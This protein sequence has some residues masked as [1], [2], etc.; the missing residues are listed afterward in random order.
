MSK[1]NGQQVWQINS[2]IQNNVVYY[3]IPMNED[4][5]ESEMTH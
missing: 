2:F 1:P 5:L 3:F 4:S